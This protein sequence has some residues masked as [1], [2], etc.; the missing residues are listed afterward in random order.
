MRRTQFLCPAAIDR[1]TVGELKDQSTPGLS[2]EVLSTGKKVWKYKRRVSGGGPLV[3]LSLGP[4]PAHSIAAAREWAEKL[5]EQAEAGI[6]PRE[7][8]R[9]EAARASM[10]VTKAHKLYM[11]A[12]REGRASRAKRKNKPRTISDKLEI[13]ER[14]IA[15]TFSSK[16]IY[17]VTERD[18]I[19]LV[20]TKGKTAKVRANRLAAELK[21]FRLG[22]VA[23][24]SGGRLGDG[25]FPPPR[26]SLVARNAEV[27]EAGPRG[28][29]LVP[30][31]ACR[32][33]ARLS[34][35][36][37]PLAPDGRAA[38]GGVGGA[39]GG[40]RRPRLVHSGLADQKLGRASDRSRP[41][42]MV[43]HAVEQRVG[44]PG[45]E[46]GRTSVAQFLVQGARPREGV[47]GGTGKAPDRAIYSS[48]F[49]PNLTLEHQAAEG[50]LRDRRGN[51]QPC[52]EGAGANLS[53]LRAGGGKARVVLEVGT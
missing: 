4:F 30:A 21:V 1:L 37:A 25:S 26:R 41:M 7:V 47:D 20:E 53:H 10:T 51:A 46:A 36:H 42:G 43:A 9:A 16:I 39:D 44:I 8:I 40:A 18:P 22:G 38:R 23:P 50:R 52:E 2:I 35:R 28:N 48:R 6:D 12:V 32:R 24:R 31:G 45:T 33:G 14:D 15:P 13:Y 34:A 27:A 29:R 11:R 17:D 3:R 5:N 19:K 49:P